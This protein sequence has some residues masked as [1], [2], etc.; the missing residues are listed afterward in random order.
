MYI[1][2]LLTT[3]LLLGLTFPKS[4]SLWPTTSVCID[5]S[6]AHSG[7]PLFTIVLKDNVQIVDTK[8]Y[9]FTELNIFSP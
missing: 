4:T 8:I 3:D 6:Q 1:R 7:P 5:R 9:H 2:Q